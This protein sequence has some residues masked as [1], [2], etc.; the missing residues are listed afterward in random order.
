MN[1][2]NFDGVNKYLIHM[3]ILFDPHYLSGK[4]QFWSPKQ[5]FAIV[6]TQERSDS[7]KFNPDAISQQIY[8][9]YYKTWLHNDKKW[10]I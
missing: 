2:K 6:E 9:L 7:L 5:D 3:H 4:Y 1:L 8:L 10:S